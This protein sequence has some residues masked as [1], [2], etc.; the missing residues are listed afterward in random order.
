VTLTLLPIGQEIKSHS[1]GCFELY[2]FDILVDESLKAW[3]LEVNLSP[4]LGVDGPVDITVKKAMLEDMVD[5]LQ[6]TQEDGDLAIKYQNVKEF[7]LADGQSRQIKT[8]Q[9]YQ[10]NPY[11]EAA[12]AA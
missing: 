5:L 7:K 6:I 1:P 2:G 3:L 10:R 12:S 4:A 8:T 11:K 9:P